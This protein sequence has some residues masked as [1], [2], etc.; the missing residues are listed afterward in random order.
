[1]RTSTI[2]WI[3]VIVVILLGGWY[4]WIQSSVP[5]PAPTASTTTTPVTSVSTT[6][7]S[8]STPTTGDGTGIAE[9]LILGINAGTGSI[10]TFLSAYNGMTV[11]TYSPDSAT[12]GKSSCTGTCAS[13]WPPYTVSSVSDINVPASITGTV[14]T[15][16]RTDGSLQVTYNGAPLYLY[17]KDA[18]PGDT[19]GQGVG[20][21]WYV[22]TP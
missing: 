9:N 11:Y 4:L 19:N 1:M 13:T 6:T 12:P 18:K 10:P 20:G 21:V 15:I 22:A 8:T 5:S 17:I 16:T 2:V 14:G 7:A 3:V